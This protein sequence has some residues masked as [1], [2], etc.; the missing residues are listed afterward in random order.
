MMNQV[1][2]SSACLSRV[3]WGLPMQQFTADGV[4]GIH[5]ARRK[6]AFRFLERDKSSIGLLLMRMKQ[7]DTRLSCGPERSQP[8]SSFDSVVGVLGMKFETA[9]IREVQMRRRHA[10]FGFR[11]FQYL[12]RISEKIL[13]P[14]QPVKGPLDV[15]HR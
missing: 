5:R 8:R 6:L 4:V 9:W 14:R 2:S 7:P 13:V 10:G 1:L 3:R 11:P 12:H 15:L